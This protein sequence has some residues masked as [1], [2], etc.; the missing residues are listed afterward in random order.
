[1]QRKQAPTSEP[2][3]ENTSR[4][5][6]AESLQE[7]G[8]A[9]KEQLV[10]KQPASPHD[11]E[12]DW[13]S[14]EVQRLWLELHALKED[15]A[16]PW[17]VRLAVPVLIASLAG[18]FSAW[19]FSDSLVEQ[20]RAD[21]R[22]SV[23]DTYFG[24]NNIEVGKRKQILNFV[25][26]VLADDPKFGPWVVVERKELEKTSQAV[27]KELE[28]LAQYEDLASLAKIDLAKAE[29]ALAEIEATLNQSADPSFAS[30]TAISGK[31]GRAAF[32]TRNRSAT[33]DR[34]NEGTPHL[35]ATM[36]LDVA[37]AKA[38]VAQAKAKVAQ[39]EIK[40]NRTRSRLE[41]SG[42]FMLQEEG[43]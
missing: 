18:S 29:T 37:R 20:T 35:R 16:R 24:L 40:T 27:A 33:P 39:A 13:R 15:R 31:T 7:E 30:A 36:Q 8:Q 14:F 19:L 12:E 10:A 1:M 32:E 6:G 3:P 5:P 11:L 42:F 43:G 28:R 23:L 25:E 34:A 4:T 41:G 2:V 22:K 26:Q 38:N 17:L 21:M 9:L